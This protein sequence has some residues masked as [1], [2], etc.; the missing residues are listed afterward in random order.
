MYKEKWIHPA[1]GI[2]T[3]TFGKRINPILNKEEFHTGIDISM[4]EG[5]ELLALKSGIITEVNKSKTYGNYIKF[6]T[7]DGYEIMYAHLKK[8]KVKVNSKIDQNQIIALSGNTGLSTGPHLH[9]SIWIN[10][11]LVDPRNFIEYN[12]TQEAKN[13]ILNRGEVLK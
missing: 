2:I 4:D 9:L 13:E 7:N 11:I 3:S 6:E 5:T 1:N 10:G 12:L 8:A